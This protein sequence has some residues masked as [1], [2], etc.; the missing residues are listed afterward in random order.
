MPK[1][2]GFISTRFAGT[3]GVSLES[4]KWAEVLWDDRHVSYW[5]SG[6]SDREPGISYVVPEAYFGHPEI[7]WINERIWGRTSREPLVTTRIREMTDYL[8]TSLYHFVKKFQIDF[9]IPQ[10]VLTIPMHLP[11][12]LAVTEFLAETGMPAIAHH[13]DFFWERTRFSVNGVGDYLDSAF[14]PSLNNIRSVV[15]NRPAEE[16]IALRKGLASLLIP[17]VFDFDKP[18]PQPDEYSADVREEIGLKPDDVFILQPTRIVP[19]KGIEHA[20][21]MVGMLKDPRYKLV[22]SHDAGDEGLDYLHMLNELA[23]EENVDVRF[24]ADRVSEVRQYDSLG[25]KMYTL[26]DLYPHADFVTYPSTY[27]G[28]GNALLETVYFRKPMMVNRYSIYIQDI[29]P[30]GFRF[31]EMDGIVTKKVVAHVQR[32]LEDSHYRDEMVEHNYRVARRFYSYTVLRR[33]LRTLMTSLT[34]WGNG[35]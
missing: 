20:I 33:S 30:R 28:F 27:E 22:I 34:G 35:G 2:I 6:R 24:I 23:K 5:Y 19:R 11:L 10:N 15:I 25:R 16:Q 32:I 26:W 14:P 9:I 21:K 13:H 17:N 18:A 8:K 31:A 3:D 12:G 29:E 1:N 7:E 4:A